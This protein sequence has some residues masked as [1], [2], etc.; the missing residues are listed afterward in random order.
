MKIRQYFLELWLKTSG[1]FLR[2]SVHL[3]QC[4]FIIWY[5]TK[6]VKFKGSQLWSNLPVN[7][8]VLLSYVSFKCKLK[9]YLIRE[10][11]IQQTHQWRH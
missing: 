3:V 7:L 1:V 9:V 11:D 10:L 4:V 6:C 8:S 2:H 5:T